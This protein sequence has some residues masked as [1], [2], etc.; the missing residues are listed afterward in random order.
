MATTG[1]KLVQ[2]SRIG[3]QQLLRW[4]TV[5]KSRPGFKTVNKQQRHK[6]YP[7]KN[8]LSPTL[9]HAG[10]LLVHGGSIL[11]KVAVLSW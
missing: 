10:G 4:P 5:A 9:K 2:R 11:K 7:A 6:D 8:V 3:A 1:V